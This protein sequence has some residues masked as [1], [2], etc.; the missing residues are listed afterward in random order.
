MRPRVELDRFES[1]LQSRSGSRKQRDDAATRH[2]LAQARLTAARQA[3]QAAREMAAR[4]R[5][6]ARPEELDAA[7]ARL[8]ATEAQVDSLEKQVTDAT[9]TAPMSGIV[10]ETLADVGEL[11]APGRPMLVLTDLDRAWANIYVAEPVVPTGCGSGRTRRSRP[12]PEAPGWRAASP[13][14]HRAPSSRLAT[15]K[16]SE[17]RAK[18][19]YRIK[20]AVDNRGTA[21][22]SRACRSKPCCRSPHCHESIRA[23][24]SAFDRVSHRYGS[25]VALDSLSLTVRPRRDVRADRA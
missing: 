5:S 15:F 16:T 2:D 7:R 10:T 1:L 25:A 19:V 6:G 11:L 21:C 17:E 24:E 8:L 13:S 14:S 4:L 20:I 22:S 9:L 12:T 23:S 3:V 18:L